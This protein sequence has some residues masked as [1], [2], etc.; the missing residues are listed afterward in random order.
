MVLLPIIFLREIGSIK[1][2]WIEKKRMFIARLR[3]EHVV[4]A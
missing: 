4:L 3:G 1:V 2:A